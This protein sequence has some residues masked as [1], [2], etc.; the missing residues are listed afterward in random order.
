MIWFVS[1][2]PNIKRKTPSAVQLVF[3]LLS[4]LQPLSLAKDNTSHLY[5]LYNYYISSNHV[6]GIFWRQ[7]KIAALVFAGVSLQNWAYRP[8]QVAM[9][10]GFHFFCCAVMI[11]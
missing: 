2:K 10:L 4:M 9:I 1:D 8:K 5:Y 7:Q 3:F 11:V 6:D